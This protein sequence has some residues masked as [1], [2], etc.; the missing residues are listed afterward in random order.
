M[1]S[2]QN[3]FEIQHRIGSFA[4]KSKEQRC[5]FVQCATI[6][7]DEI[8]DIITKEQL[9]RLCH[10]SKTT[11]LHLLR[12]GIIPCKRSDKKT[13]CYQI[14]KEDVRKYLE[15]RAVLAEEFTAPVGWYC[16]GHKATKKEV[17]PVILEDMS[18]Y[19]IDRLKAYPDVLTVQQIIVFTGY[20]KTAINNWCSKGWL[21][22][23][24]KRRANMV[25]KVFFIE[26]LGS[27]HFR[28]IRRKTARHVKL[29]KGFRSWKSANS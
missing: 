7:W 14:K 6:D 12:S 26:F 29:L 21:K 16:S 24:T 5:F 8:P 18:D 20:K 28:K 27:D 22:H 17:P 9:Y 15:E 11:A 23:F 10:I 2:R 3:F 4:D 1:G 13:H 19:Y 25:P